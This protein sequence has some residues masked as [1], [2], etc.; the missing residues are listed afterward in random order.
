[1]AFQLI[2]ISGLR[3]EGRSEA[4]DVGEFGGTVIAMGV[5]DTDPVSAA[6]PE[7]EAAQSQEA[8][9]GWGTTYFLVADESKPHPVWVAK[10]EVER[11]RLA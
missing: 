4:P 9:S 10:H 8:L 7:M 6:A 1:M 3:V 2:P 11:H 5:Q